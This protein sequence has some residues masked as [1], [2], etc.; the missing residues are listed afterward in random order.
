M[1]QMRLDLPRELN[2]LLRRYVIEADKKSREKATIF[3]LDNFLV[4]LY[5][6]PRGDLK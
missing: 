3:I 2:K 5:G 1:A 4:Q 6:K